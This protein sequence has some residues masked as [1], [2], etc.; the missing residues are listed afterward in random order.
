GG[1]DPDNR[2]MLGAEGI[3]QAKAGPVYA[4]LKK[5]NALRAAAAPLRRGKQTRLLGAEHQYAFRRDLG[6]ETAAVFLNK[7]GA[8]V[9]LKAEGLPDG[10][11]R[12]L[13]TGAKL[14]VKGG[15][16]EAEVPAHGLR[17][18][19]KGKIKGAPWRVTG[20]PEAMK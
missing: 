6:R 8:A 14:K 10:T 19:M 7:G 20:G 11:Y 4:H 1:S 3:K 13:Y 17:I 15:A 2:R 18:Y 16:L 9:K 5:L 12:E